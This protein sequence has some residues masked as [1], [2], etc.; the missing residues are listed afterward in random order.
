MNLQ[1]MVVNFATIPIP[2]PPHGVSLQFPTLASSSAMIWGWI[3]PLNFSLSKESLKSMKAF[4]D[5]GP[6]HDPRLVSQ[7]LFLNS[8]PHGCCHSPIR[9]CRHR[10]GLAVTPGVRPD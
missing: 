4:N 10:I 3:R 1:E 7:H 6:Y 5:V 8:L 9:H 2:L